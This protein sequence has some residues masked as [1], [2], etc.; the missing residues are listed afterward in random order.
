MSLACMRQFFHAEIYKWHKKWRIDT[1][2][3][4]LAHQDSHQKKDKNNTKYH[5]RKMGKEGQ[6][7]EYHFGSSYGSID[8]E[9]H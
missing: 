8:E 2:Y 4:N 1:L 5:E 6:M 7:T 9:A 3:Q